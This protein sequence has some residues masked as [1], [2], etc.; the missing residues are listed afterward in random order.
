MTGGLFPSFYQLYLLASSDEIAQV[1]ER[2]L[3][4]EIGV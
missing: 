4:L 2:R 1:A 3:D